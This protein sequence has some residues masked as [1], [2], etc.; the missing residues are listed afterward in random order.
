M[1]LADVQQVLSDE[2]NELLPVYNR[3]ASKF[4]ATNTPVND[5][6]SP[7]PGSLGHTPQ[8]SFWTLAG[9]RNMRLKS[10]V[11][12]LVTEG[13]TMEGGEKGQRGD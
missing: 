1:W 13:E 4:Y 5:W 9:H 6:S 7:Q 3:T 10:L 2:A 8:R 11:P 12:A